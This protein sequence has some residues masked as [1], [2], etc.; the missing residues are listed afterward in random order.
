[1]PGADNE[2]ASLGRGSIDRIRKP[3]NPIL[4]LNTLNFDISEILYF[5]FCSFLNYNCTFYTVLIDLT[6]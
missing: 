2:A 3:T 1:M 5:T 4:G 6:I